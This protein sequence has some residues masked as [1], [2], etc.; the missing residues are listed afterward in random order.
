[1]KSLLSSPIITLVRDLW[2]TGRHT[3]TLTK[4]QITDVMGFEFLKENYK[5]S[6][7][8]WKCTP[9]VSD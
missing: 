6:H 1:M 4:M 8:S 9:V 7:V 3:I 2:R 5:V